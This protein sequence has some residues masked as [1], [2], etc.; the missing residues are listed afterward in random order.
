MP[1]ERMAG[2]HGGAPRGACK[3][4]GEGSQLCSTRCP[5]PLLPLVSASETG[6]SPAPSPCLEL[7]SPTL[8][9]PYD[10]EPIAVTFCHMETHLGS[11]TRATTR[12][13]MLPCLTPLPCTAGE[14][15]APHLQCNV[16]IALGTSSKP[17]ANQ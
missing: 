10:Q 15:V 12:T 16:C 2:G 14:P 4:A 11:G 1:L 6:S 5:S 3:V 7:H 13:C 9:G 17:V 8:P